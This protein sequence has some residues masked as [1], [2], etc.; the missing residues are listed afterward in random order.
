MFDRSAHFARTRLSPSRQ[1]ART[2]VAVQLRRVSQR[3]EAR[4]GNDKTNE[5]ELEGRLYT[6]VEY[7]TGT[8]N[9]GTTRPEA[10]A[11]AEHV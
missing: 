7:E 6:A 2:T 8:R 5:P 10:R 1:S 9:A 3:A 11:F 4:A